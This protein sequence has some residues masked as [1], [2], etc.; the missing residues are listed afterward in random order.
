MESLMTSIRGFSPDARTWQEIADA[1][2][3]LAVLEGEVMM[4]TPPDAE[5]WREWSYIHQRI[6]PLAGF[7]SVNIATQTDVAFRV[8]RSHLAELFLANG[9][10]TTF[11]T[12]SRTGTGDSNSDSERTHR[13]RA[14]EGRRRRP[15]R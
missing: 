9:R 11:S 10:S 7:Q 5:A 4:S 8:V 13:Q 6:L 14:S 2:P 15:G 3:R 1:E 12:N